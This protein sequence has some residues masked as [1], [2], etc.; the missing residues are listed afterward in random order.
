[1]KRRKIVIGDPHG[2]LVETEKILELAEYNPATDDVFF[3]GDLIHRGPD[4]KGCFTLMKKINARAVLGNHELEHLLVKNGEWMK[5]ERVNRSIAEFGDLYG[6]FLQDI[7][8]WPLYIEDEDFTLIHAGL[9]PGKR[10]AEM[11]PR[12]ITS[13][14]R[15]AD[16]VN[17]KDRKPWFDYYTDPKLLLFG[18]WSQL[19]GLDRPNCVGLDM[20]CVYGRTLRAIIMP[21]RKIIDIQA[22]KQYY[23]PS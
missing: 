10:P 21:E 4:S 14:R 18:H 19:G 17:P 6:F 5:S 12:E 2:C 7:E 8:S 3:T 11:T 16:P 9:L 20:G 15:I 23:V 22:E 1:M 13:I